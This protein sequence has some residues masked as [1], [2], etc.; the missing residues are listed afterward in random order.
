MAGL[1]NSCS[2]RMSC[3]YTERM[4][5]QWANASAKRVDAA[6]AFRQHVAEHPEVR[7]R[8][9]ESVI[10]VLAED[11]VSTVFGYLGNHHPSGAT[12]ACINEGV[13]SVISVQTRHSDEPQ[14]SKLTV[15]PNSEIGM[16]FHLLSYKPDQPFEIAI[17]FPDY[18][19]LLQAE[20]LAKATLAG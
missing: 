8:I 5:E 2:K 14:M 1:M 12:L 15:A 18:D 7:H 19:N 17:K 13:I 6:R 3:G 16:L 20:R 9:P 4:A 10:V 11:S